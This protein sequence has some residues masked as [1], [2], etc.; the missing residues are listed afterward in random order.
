MQCFTCGLKCAILL[1]NSK[2]QYKSILF[3]GLIEP[4]K[5]KIKLN[6]M[7]HRGTW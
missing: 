7:L 1:S 6:N 3:Y 2:L 5:R 4:L